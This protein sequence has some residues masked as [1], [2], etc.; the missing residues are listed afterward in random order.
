MACVAENLQTLGNS[1]ITTLDV[2]SGLLTHSAMYMRKHFI[3]VVLLV[4]VCATLSAHLHP[5]PF[6]TPSFYE[7]FQC[8]M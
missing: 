1:D 6:I 5:E 2:Y 4:I 3:S 7:L 8:N